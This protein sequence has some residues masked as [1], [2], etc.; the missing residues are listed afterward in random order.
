MISRLATF[1]AAICAATAVQADSLPKPGDF[2]LISRDQAGKFLGSHKLF[3]HQSAD[4]KQVTYCGNE[5]FV[6]DSS[7]AWTELQAEFGHVVH[8][9]FNFGKGW[10]PI[11]ANPERE[12]TLADIGI[13]LDAREVLAG[14]ST[15]HSTAKRLATI[16]A[17]FRTSVFEKSHSG[18][19]M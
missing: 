16:G 9:E 12:V 10:R 11:C 6:R 2:Y 7:V 3:R 8:V 1:L 18:L 15:E 19:G 17:M 13:S 4:L 5:Y 14:V